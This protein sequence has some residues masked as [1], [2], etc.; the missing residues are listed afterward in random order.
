MAQTAALSGGAA[1]RG[2]R[3]RRTLLALLLTALLTG[4]ALTAVPQLGRSAYVGRVPLT[5]VVLAGM[6]AL[7]E[8]VVLH[9]Q[10]RREA[11][12]VSLSE[13]VTVL[14]LFFATPE[15]LLVG[16]VLGSVAV[17]VLHRR[18]S[19]LKTAF[20][21][22]LVA[23]EAALALGLFD[24]LTDPSPVPGP[25][26]WAAALAAVLVSST[27][28]VVA[29]QLVV[30]VYEG[31]FALRGLLRECLSG[32][33]PTLMVASLSVVAVLCLALDARSSW[34]LLVPAGGLMLAY[35]AHARLSDR[36]LRLER[37]YRFSQVVTSSSEIDAVL[38]SVL[39]EARELLRAEHVVIRFLPAVVDRSALQV[40]LA[41][42]G[43]LERIELTGK[44]DPEWLHAAVVREGRPVLAARGTRDAGAAAWLERDGH[45]EAIVVPLR[46][47]AGVVGS[48]RVADRT[49]E[50][51]AFDAAD[52]LLL[53][54]V[55]N[56]AG[57]SLQNGRLVDRLRH[58]ALHDALTGLP[59]R[60]QLQGVLA[61][62]VEKVASG[63]RQGATVMVLDLDG[64]KDVNDT[65]GHACGDRLL[66][67]ISRRL[68]AAVGSAGFVARLGGDEFAIV[69]PST[70]AQPEVLAA[71]G[72]VLESLRNPVALDGM[73]VEVGGSIGI[74]LAPL[75]GTDPSVLLKRADMAMY[76]AKGS[77]G[78]LRV[79]EVDLDT[80]DPRRLAL[81]AELRSALATD[82]LQVHFQPIAELVTGRVRGVEALVRWV[83]PELGEVHPDEL[84]PIAERSGLIGALT[85]HVL[86]QSLATCAQLC[87]RGLDLGVAVNLST[88]SLVDL[89]FVGEVAAL[90]ARHEV[91]GRL[92][93]LE[94]TEGV[95]MADPQRAA[96][97][98]A[99]LRALGVRLSLDD[100]GTGYS[101]L[102]YLTQLPVDE[103]KIDRSFVRRICSRPDDVAVVRSVV[104]LGRGLNLDVVAE[105]VED[106]E[107]WQVLRTL[108]CTHGQGW[109]LG[110]PMPA[111]ELVGWLQD[112]ADRVRVLA[113]R[114]PAA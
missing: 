96:V 34:V 20:N 17:F 107:T 84:V 5:W 19:P 46:G 91:P 50:V 23:A 76:G 43:T 113:G 111:R 63:R 47:E 8:L 95:V 54:T 30:A 73:L 36:H 85:S 83:H 92:L 39:A 48:L 9:V 77:G 72:R 2:D 75:H 24:L 56:H 7:T 104:E 106:L 89:A 40:R 21:T 26:S 29:L 1:S 101:S 12:A 102:A 98:L 31:G 51:R 82:Q 52:V 25:T 33:A 60:V 74:A 32:V 71:G 45:R 110:R 61:D 68:V 18:S 11:Q 78:G 13:L 41:E 108:G 4:V 58:D 90:L 94:I 67:E 35:R 38:R 86:E 100:F 88:R 81:V 10:V 105:G 16:R 37:L 87:G 103:I 53:A 65:L 109:Y 44:A 66:Q 99:E 80:D 69:L 93:T 14:A 112:R 79:Y 3:F 97:L 28:G 55:A 22:A 27:L 6:F 70:A 15:A 49:G 64:F 114:A 57:T 62:A 42:D 59:N